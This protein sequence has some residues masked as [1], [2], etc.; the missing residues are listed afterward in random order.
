LKKNKYGV[1]LFL[2]LLSCV[3]FFSFNAPIFTEVKAQGSYP[4]TYRG[5]NF[6]D[7]DYGNGTH[8]WRSMPQAVWNGSAWCD[9]LYSRDEA[10]K[11]YRVKVGLIS[12]EIYDSGIAVFYDINMTEQRIKSE[13]WELWD[14]VAVKKATLNTPVTFSVV[15]NSSGVY[16]N[17]TRTTSKPS[18]VL[19]VLYCFRVGSPLKHYVYWKSS[20]TMNYTVAVKQVWDLAGFITKCQVD[21][22]EKTSGT[23][24]ATR[25]L[26]YN[27][28]K[29][30]REG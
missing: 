23:Y 16:I 1:L 15:Q 3:T 29:R 21:G 27:E 18:G 4:I 28:T 6:E 14:A 10:K 2:F 17:A 19:T 24:N 7:V 9:Y 11:C 12:G 22:V 13:L 26:F 8:V 5:S 30:K 20:E 25:F